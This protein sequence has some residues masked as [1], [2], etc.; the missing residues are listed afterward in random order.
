MVEREK[1][2]TE[3]QA[4]FCS[5]GYM[6]D[7]STIGPSDR[8]VLAGGTD[9]EDLTPSRALKKPPYMVLIDGPRA[10]TYFPLSEKGK[11]IIGRAVGTAIRLEDQSVSRQH[12]EIEKTS[13]GWSIKDLGS[14][15][16]TYVNNSV[17]T[18]A[19]VIGHKDLVKVGIYLLRLVTQNISTEEEMALPP[20]I[21]ASEKTIFA[22]TPHPPDSLTKEIEKEEEAIPEESS[23][24]E[25][26]F[27]EEQGLW[28]RYNIRKWIFPALGVLC[29]IIAGSM[30]AKKFLS[31]PQ[32]AEVASEAVPEKTQTLPA[33]TVVNEQAPE[34]TVEPPKPQT[35]P[36]FLDLASSP[37]SAVVIFEGNELG[38]TPLRVNLD[39]EVNKTFKVEGKFFMPELNET[40]IQPVDF[41]VKAGDSIVPVFFRA[42]IGM[43][44]V[45]NLP[46]D[47]QFYLE[48]SFEYDRFKERPAKLNEIIMQKPIYLPYGSYK[49]ELRK[50]RQLGESETYVSDIIFKREF[51][52]AEEEP[53]YVIEVKDED[54]QK[55]PVA[56]NTDPPVADLFID[57]KLMGQTPYK[58][59]FPLGDH[60]LTIRK[61]GYFEHTQELK[62]DINTLFTADIKLETSVAGAHL[63]NAIA[64]INR[65]LY[66]Q[67]VNELAQAL[68]S[69]PI[70]PEI[71]NAN[72]LLG[73]SYLS[74]GDVERALT[75]FAQSKK[76]EKWR[77]RSMLGEV[78]A[79]HANGATNQAIPI[80][81]EVL[82]KNE[83]E[84]IKK[85]AN[86][87]FQ[88]ISPFRSIVYVY[89][90][91]DGARVI[92]N[93]K[94]VDNK[95][96]VILHDLPLGSYKLR[97]EK[98][99]YWPSELKLTLSVNE[100][101]PVIVT[102][103]PIV[104]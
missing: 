100:F 19:V 103:K 95:T 52:I 56:V 16:G 11:N 26:L 30:L 97:I 33:Q 94:E 6:K 53:T 50:T 91:P 59:E 10:G 71:D 22:E 2:E 48:G 82:L 67:A 28:E 5:W 89:S 77:Y 8:T 96:P 49:V 38:K 93:D 60:T 102:L 75:Y 24:E 54:L 57:G 81:V 88:K 65:E 3:R 86:D 99:G 25:D 40:F 87:L 98:P 104:E 55:F 34:V 84:E 83:D 13:A 61:E 37:M 90:E 74:L 42:P 36:I 62:V 21:A 101:N 69:Q 64:M 7:E 27:E 70:Q 78:A 45:N 1:L 9:G 20:E 79:Y 66:Q 51:L 47:V 32:E 80:L 4:S 15:N 23:S 18:E 85:E 63:N 46:R 12:S 43:I 35:M 58:G 14:K 72:Y 29:V 92:V 41:E 39:L 44:K 73:R 76:S 68:A 17:A 31:K